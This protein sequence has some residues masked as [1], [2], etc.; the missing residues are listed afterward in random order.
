MKSMSPELRSRIPSRLHHHNYTTLDHEKTRAFYED[1]LGFP[2]VAFWT[3]IEPL[4]QNDGKDVIM[5]HAFYGLGDGSML[6]FMHFADPEF[7]ERMKAPTQPMGI[8][9]ALAVTRELQAA[10]VE[11]LRGAGVPVMEID[12]GFVRSIYFT[13]PNGLRVEF[14]SDPDNVDEIYGEQADSA[15]AT[16][17]QYIAG[18]HRKTNRWLPEMH[19]APTYR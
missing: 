18:D 6:A 7:A 19:E 3:E 5:G 1:L 13:D 10:T 9:L 4:P 15:H 2:L 11:K 14:A 12:H 17:R 16:M 8:H